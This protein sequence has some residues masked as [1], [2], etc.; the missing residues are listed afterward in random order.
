M[1]GGNEDFDLLRELIGNERASKVAEALGGSTIYI[2]RNDIIAARYRS[3]KQEFCSGA[4]YRELAVKYGYTK[5]HIR[6]I[7][8]KRK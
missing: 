3:I 8:H 7:V 4:S 6:K 2:P 1:N 5:S